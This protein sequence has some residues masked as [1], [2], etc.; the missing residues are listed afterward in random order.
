M[1]VRLIGISVCVLLGFFLFWFFTPW[2]NKNKIKS[3][4]FA[5]ILPDFIQLMCYNNSVIFKFALA[6]NTAFVHKGISNAR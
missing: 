3:D 4:C 6:I 5:N 1:V 2:M